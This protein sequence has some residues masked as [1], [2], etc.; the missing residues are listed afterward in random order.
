MTVLTSVVAISAQK[1]AAR[2]VQLGYAPS[3]TS[4]VSRSRADEIGA[5]AAEPTSQM[6][7]G[8]S[9]GHV[10]RFLI[11]HPHGIGKMQ[12]LSLGA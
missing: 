8:D 12:P 2:E 9:L 5:A 6:D 10:F 1:V 4:D 7:D 11:P 3:A